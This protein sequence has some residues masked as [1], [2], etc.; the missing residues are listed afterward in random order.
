[1]RRLWKP[2]ELFL[3]AL[4]GRR[5]DLVVFSASCLPGSTP[6]D[7]FSYPGAQST[8]HVTKP[9]S[10]ATHQGARDAYPVPQTRL[11]YTFSDFK[12]PP[13][14]GE[15]GQR[16]VPYAVVIVSSRRV[17]WCPPDG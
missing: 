3:C 7:F 6:P 9:T 2:G 15:R 13:R 16:G 5:V 10:P 11:P 8:F 14:L 1:M 17:D 4:Q 12:R